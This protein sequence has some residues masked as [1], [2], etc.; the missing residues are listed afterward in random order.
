[1][2]NI[3]RSII[4]NFELAESKDY[5]DITYILASSVPNLN[6]ALFTSD[7]L[8]KAKDSI[9]NQPLIIVPDFGNFPTG[10]SI[11][12]FPKIG[13]GASIIGTHTASEIVE[14]NGIEHLKVTARMWKIRYPE[15]AAVIMKL[16]TMGKLKFSMECNYANYEMVGSARSL[17]GVN[18]IGS[19]V[20]DEPAN[21]YSVSLEVARL[22]SKEDSNMNEEQ[23]LNTEALEEEQAAEEV[24]P[25]CKK[26]LNECECEK[27][28]AKDKKK[29]CGSN[30]EQV[31]DVCPK[32][33]KPMNECT[34]EEED[35]KKKKKCGTAEVEALEEALKTANARIAELESE[36]ASIHEEEEKAKFEELKNQ[37]FNTIAEFIEF[38]EEEV[39]SKKEMYA[40]L[41][42]DVF[43]LVLE[44]AKASK[45][46]EKQEEI[47]G[48]DSDVK[49]NLKPKRQGFLDGLGEK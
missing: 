17:K 1:M 43:N 30:E 18:F 23:V 46:V 16:H 15:I 14:E 19:A 24:C 27:E 39:E 26:P 37:R 4:S 31:E 34:C 38:T 29:K 35:A 44:T 10:H 33:K 42:E 13:Y 32:C 22:Q 36:L 48:L 9:I 8:E 5:L 11:E 28:Q 40:Q 6:G 41:D 49:L 47:A 21:P 45:K 25:K 2:G 20:V 3:E 12:D 7:E